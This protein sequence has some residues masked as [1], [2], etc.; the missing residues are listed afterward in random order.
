MKII[1]N[2]CYN[3]LAFLES[4]AIG[5]SGTRNCARCGK[6]VNDEQGQ[7]ETV[8]MVCSKFHAVRDKEFEDAMKEAT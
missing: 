5:I 6:V 1:C 2:H 7:Y 4:L 8:G 3:V